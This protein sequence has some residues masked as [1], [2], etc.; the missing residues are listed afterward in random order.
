MT[1]KPP[2]TAQLEKAGLALIPN[3]AATVVQNGDKARV[4]NGTSFVVAPADTPY[5][6]LL[7]AVPN[8]WEE[9]GGLSYMGGSYLGGE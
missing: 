2:T 9:R 3:L 8:S 6:T 7:Y 5:T 4:W 1:T